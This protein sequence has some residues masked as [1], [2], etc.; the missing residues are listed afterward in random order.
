M[1]SPRYE[2]TAIS[3]VRMNGQVSCLTVNRYYVVAG[4][5]TGELWVFESSHGRSKPGSK[6]ADKGEIALSYAARASP[7]GITRIL[8]SPENYEN[9]LSQDDQGWTSVSFSLSSSFIFSSLPK[10]WNLDHVA[11]LRESI[12]VLVKATGNKFWLRLKQSE[13]SES[14]DLA[15]WLQDLPPESLGENVPDSRNTKS[16][17][18][19][20]A[21]FTVEHQGE[22]SVAA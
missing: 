10:A 22:I 5:S 17:K 2:P 14:R 15:K 7:F 6:S 11:Y 1:I 9:M 19:D 13:G 21:S 4:S 3:F 8:F 12:V 16:S 20:F 18:N